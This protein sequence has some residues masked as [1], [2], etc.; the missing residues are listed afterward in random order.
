MANPP[1]PS[2]DP[3]PAEKF[4]GLLARPFSLTPDLRFAY[5]SRSHTH[6]LEQVTSAL[7]RREGLILVTGA[8]G[9]GKTMLCRSMLESFEEKPFLSVILDPGLEVED[10]LRTVLTDFGIVRGGDPTFVGPMT[11]VTRHQFVTALQQFLSSLAQ[12]GKCAVI[13]IDEAQ[14]LN[15][16]VLEEVRL[17]TNFETDEAKLLQIVLVGQPELDDILH[18]PSM[19]QLNQRVARRCVLQ[20]LSAREVGDYIERR[21]MVAASPTAL[22]GG[23]EPA[24]ADPSRV[25]RFAPEAIA[26][27]AAISQGTP[28]LINTVCDRA[29]DVGYERQQRTIDQRSVVEAARRLRIDIPA[30]LNKGIEE[31]EPAPESELVE[32]PAASKTWIWIAAAVAAVLIATLAARWLLPRPPALVPAR[33]PSAR[34]P[35][36]DSRPAPEATTPTLPVAGGQNTSAPAAAT[37]GPGTTGNAAGGAAP[38]ASQTGTARGS[39]ATP[40]TPP[41][42]PQ[43]SAS[44]DARG[45]QPS[46]TTP[47]SA[48]SP[49]RSTTGYQITV[50]SFRAEQRA[51]DAVATLNAMQVPTAMRTDSTGTWFR[52]VVGP[53]PTR[54]EAV[55]AQQKIARGGFDGTQISQVT[56]E[57]R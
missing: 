50:A 14:R 23:A 36:T 10:L 39:A 18:Q 22:A 7:R 30:E 45:A 6:A 17:L 52:V 56:S 43:P 21:L 38:A 9:T 37:A 34:P 12:F 16:R 4:F 2:F 24:T 49:R 41:A 54:D 40:P 42:T 31:T 26:A 3:S 25:V 46:A 29:L 57:A 13:M 20:P 48:G 35:A 5:Y 1:G 19:Q 32:A 51:V 28:R 8:I 15:T 53:F 27:V 47:P 55:A 33:Q 11:D 44:A